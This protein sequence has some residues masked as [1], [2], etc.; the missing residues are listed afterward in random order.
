M[1]LATG[2]SQK[3][4]TSISTSAG[5]SAS[6]ARTRL[7]STRWCRSTDL[8]RDEDPLAALDVYDPHRPVGRVE[9]VDDAL[10]R[11][12]GHIPPG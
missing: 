5:V 9:A 4:R 8:R 2:S 6:V 7:C 11:D 10:V 3:A 12:R 1:K